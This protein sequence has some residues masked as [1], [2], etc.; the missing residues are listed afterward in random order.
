MP[1]AIH[2]DVYESMLACPLCGGSLWLGVQTDFYRCWVDGP[3][4]AITMMEIQR[5]PKYEQIAIVRAEQ[6]KA[7]IRRMCEDA[8]EEIN[9]RLNVYQNEA[10]SFR[11]LRSSPARRGN[12]HSSG[13]RRCGW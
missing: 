11:L 9:G 1:S 12:L 10:W 7:E 3:I 4:T 2:R 8:L 6:Y 5:R 13:A